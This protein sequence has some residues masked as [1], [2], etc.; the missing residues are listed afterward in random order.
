MATEQLTT[1]I[2]DSALLGGYRFEMGNYAFP[3]N[4]FENRYELSTPSLEEH[5]PLHFF[6]DAIR[7]IE[8]VEGAYFSY[9]GI[10]AGKDII[11]F[12]TVIDADDKETKKRIYSVEMELM[13]TF[14][15]TSYF[16]E[17]HVIAR[18]GRPLNELISKKCVA[19]LE[20]APS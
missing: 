5:S 9:Q 19:L 4:P 3:S 10:P 2:A 14:P 1:L 15:K 11:H 18:R 20:R 8:N 12:H 17:F 13:K 7:K 6:K 16:F